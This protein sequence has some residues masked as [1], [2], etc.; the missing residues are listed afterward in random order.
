MKERRKAAR[1]KSAKVSKAGKKLWGGGYGAATAGVVEQFTESV[2][3]DKR[4]APFDIRGSIAHATMLG[5][6]GIISASDSRKI[7]AGLKA[8]LK[9]VEA[10]TFVW[11]ASLEDVHMNIESTLTRRIASATGSDAGARLH[12]GRSRND[13]VATAFRLW[14][15]DASR[16]LVTAAGSLLDALRSVSARD[17]QA[18]LPGYTH[19]QQAQ[20]VLLRTHLGAYQEMLRRDVARLESAESSAMRACPLGSGALAGS[21]LP[22]DRVF[23]ARELGFMRP[24]ANPMDAVSDRDFAVELLFACALLQVHLSRLSEDLILWSS[25]EFGFVRLDDAV[26]TGSSLMPQK[27]NPDVCELARGKSGRVVGGL[28]S[29]LVTL[30]GLPLTYNRDLQ[31]DKEGVFDVV[32]TVRLSLEAMALTVKTMKFNAK[33]ARAAIDP[34]ILA[35]DLAEHLVEKGVPFRHAHEIVARF[36]HSGADLGRA[37]AKMLAAA[38]PKL[39][40]AAGRLDPAE[41]V[42]R[43]KLRDL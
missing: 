7:V 8:I 11:D 17:G 4:L 25:K 30:K 36:V 42:R 23:T 22:L 1:A 38:H 21:S 15:A 19:L 39:A 24:S 27:K 3:Y 6:Q 41:A 2:S 43:R 32:D 26:T 31:E 29:L 34:S 16:R 18:L 37:D 28:V 14:C 33:R 20:P 13:Q 12:T 5:R 35:T 9:D 40:D 10:G